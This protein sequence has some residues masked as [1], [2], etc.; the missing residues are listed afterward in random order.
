MVLAR[1][2]RTWR[3]TPAALSPASGEPSQTQLSIETL[4]SDTFINVSALVTGAV[5]TPR[6]WAF[7]LSAAVLVMKAPDAFRLPQFWAEDGTVFFAQQWGHIT[8]LLFA[9]YAGYLLVMPRLIAWLANLLPVEH[10]P[11]V[12]ILCATLMGAA[13][14]ASLR[15][16]ER[17]GIP[18]V[19]TIAVFALT[20]TSGEILGA[21]TNVQWLLQFHLLAFLVRFATDAENLPRTKGA[22]VMLAVAL[23]G[24]LAIFAC[25][26]LF[27]ILVMRYFLV[28][29]GEHRMR[30]TLQ[31]VSTGE[32][33]ALSLGATVQATSLVFATPVQAQ[34]P[35]LGLLMGIA[36]ELQ[37]LQIH[38]LGGRVSANG[39]FLG[40]FFALMVTVCL[41]LRRSPPLI[42]FLAMVVFVVLQFIAV[43][44]KFENQPGILAPLL[45]GDRYFVA[46]K[47]L[48]WWS[49]VLCAL[50]LVSRQVAAA[51]VLAA[52]IAVSVWT[53]APLRRPALADLKW[54]RYA[55][56][57]QSGAEFVV[58]P[59]NPVPWTF[60]V[61]G[62][63]RNESR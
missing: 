11:A 12:Y 26:A 54:H 57:I 45:N 9:P 32:V 52:L 38:V 51:L 25:A 61:A 27:S 24:P 37:A 60:E 17:I 33:A 36:S 55:R 22:I 58:I 42:A 46:A 1:L 49:L 35:S 14:M 19:L 5:R 8:P 3:E 29:G 56:R 39:L 48:F 18:F 4:E 23:T 2:S 47:T 41:R 40:V 62:N 50:M 63:K 34:S 10:A 59:I 16:M 15:E 31:S 43:A 21:L 30:Q 7:F 6:S 28:L 44:A 53:D 13:A 20:P